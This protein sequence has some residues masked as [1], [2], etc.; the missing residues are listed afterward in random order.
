MRLL[1]RP[2][3]AAGQAAA[4]LTRARW[5]GQWAEGGF[6]IY[7]GKTDRGD[8]AG[9]AGRARPGRARVLAFRP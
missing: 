2:A 4:G 5:Q 3:R 8:H 1:A 7:N 6:R 9:A